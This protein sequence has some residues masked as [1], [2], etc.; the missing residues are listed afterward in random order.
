V[1][2]HG[3]VLGV[4]SEGDLIHRQELG[5]ETERASSLGTSSQTEAGHADYAKSHGMHARDVMTREVISVSEDTSLAEVAKTLET[6]HIK[7]VLV[8]RGTKLVGLVT[9][10]DIVRALAA[11]PAGSVGPVSSDD[12]LIR[13]QVIDTLMSMPGTSPWATTVRVTN[14]VVEL[15]GSVEEEAAREPSRIAVENLPYVVEV[16]DHRV[17]LQPY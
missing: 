7:R 5:T 2:E 15:R 9:R 6:K 11:R 8:V 3:A 14:G 17:I 12:D 4:V 16:K 10:A 13:Y 1:V